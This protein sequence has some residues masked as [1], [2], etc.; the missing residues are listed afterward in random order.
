MG[1]LEKGL[2]SQLSSLKSTLEGI[3]STVAGT[4]FEPLEATIGAKQERITAA[5]STSASLAKTERE[6]FAE[7]FDKFLTQF[8][9]AARSGTRQGVTEGFGS[10]SS[11]VARFARMGA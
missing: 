4:E 1:S 11:D 6:Q 9:D 8:V 7:M 5:Q 10:G 3:T 2:K